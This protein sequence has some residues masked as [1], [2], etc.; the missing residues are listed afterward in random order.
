MELIARIVIRRY[1]M[2]EASAE[3][4][5]RQEPGKSLAVFRVQGRS[6][7]RA[8]KLLLA[9]ID[10]P[11]NPVVVLALGKGQVSDSQQSTFVAAYSKSKTLG[12]KVVVCGGDP[13]LMFDRLAVYRDSL[14]WFP[15]LHAYVSSLELSNRH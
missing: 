8:M 10:K 9:E 4:P 13:N 3:H 6:V 12:A 14:T 11:D 15:N 2:G 1:D 5:L 7:E